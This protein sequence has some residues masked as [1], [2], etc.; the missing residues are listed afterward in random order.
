VTYPGGGSPS[1][2][3][4]EGADLKG[5]VEYNPRY[6]TPMPAYGM[7]IRHATGVELHDV[8]LMFG[9][10]EA[11]PAVIARDVDGLSLDGFGA[12]KG[13][14]PSLELDGVKNLTIK[15][16]APLAD[17]TMPSVGKVTF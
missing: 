8:K 10:S 1:G 13:S 5:G 14:G 9:G 17:T 2:D 7:F 16:S 15:G 12:Q 11:R 4:P 3:P 6:I